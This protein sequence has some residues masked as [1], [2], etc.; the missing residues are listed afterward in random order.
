MKLISCF[1]A[2]KTNLNYLTIYYNARHLQRL[3]NVYLICMLLAQNSKV[4]SYFEL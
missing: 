4:K 2:N 1:F 3:K